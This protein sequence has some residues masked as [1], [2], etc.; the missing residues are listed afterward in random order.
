MYYKSSPEIRVL[1]HGD[2]FLGIGKKEDI[3]NLLKYLGTQ[4]ELKTKIIGGT[5]DI[6]EVKMLNK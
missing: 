1:V 5:S 6:T 4:W 2:D 3:D